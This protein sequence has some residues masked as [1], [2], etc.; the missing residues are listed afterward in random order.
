MFRFKT[1]CLSL[2]LHTT[3]STIDKNQWNNILRDANPFL[4]ISFKRAFEQSHQ[5]HITH[6]FYVLDKKD[7]KQLGYAQEFYLFGERVYSYQRRNQLTRGLISLALK[8]LKLKV[9]GLGNGLIT[10]VHNVFTEKPLE[11]HSFI[12]SLLDLI[13]RERKISRFIIPD[14][15]FSKLGI[16][17]PE[18]T[19]SEL[20][21]VEVEEDMVLGL[22]PKWKQFDDYSRSLK[23]KYRARQRGVMNKSQVITI[24]QLSKSELN[25]YQDTIQQL[26]LNVQT[27]SSFGAIHFNT[28]IF[29]ELIDQSL[30]KC[31][32]YGYFLNKQMIAFS[33]ELEDSTRLYSYF[34]GLDYRYNQSHRLYERIL[35]ESIRHAISASKQEI[36]FGRTAAEFKSNVGAEP[37]RSFIYIYIKNPLLRF[38]LKP[39]LLRIKPKKWTQRH[40]F[41]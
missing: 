6:L 36:I 4:S 40:P 9:V 21:K 5:Q 3:T 20:I 25:T 22:N 41:N 33:S 28:A 29:Q 2:Q 17:I 8:V 10:N 26:F 30:P 16:R 24:R 38:I 7:N 35:L 39:I 15:F 31:T 34:I 1:H 12:H 23:K 11:N 32:V 18:K 19:I 27:N 14:H 13:S 37:R